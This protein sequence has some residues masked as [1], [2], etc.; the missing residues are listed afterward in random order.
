MKKIFLSISLLCAV[1]FTYA[2]TQLLTSWSGQNTSTYNYPQAGTSTS[3]VSSSSQNYNGLNTVSDNRNVWGNPNASSVLDPAT[4][5]YLE[6]SITT[7]DSIDF[8]RFVLGGAANMNTSTKMQLRWDVDSFGS[9]LGEFTP[10]GSN[11]NLTSVDINAQSN[12]PAGTVVFRIYYYNGIGN[13]FHVGYFG[14]ASVD[15]TPASYGV[16]GS[17]SFGIWG[18]VPV[19]PCTPTSATDVV[20]ACNSYT[21]I[22]GITYTAS[23]N[24]ATDTL[25]NAA[26]C[27]SVVS[28]DL[29][30]NTA[31]SSADTLTACDSYSWNGNMYTVSGSYVDTL[32]GVNTCDSI[33]TLELTITHSSSSIDS[34]TACDSYA[35]I[36]GYT[37]YYSNY[38]DTHI[39]TNAA[40]CDSIVT[41]ALTILESTHS[42]TSLFTYDSSYT[43]NGNVYD[44]SNTYTHNSTNAAGCDS[45]TF[46]DLTFLENP[47]DSFP[48]SFCINDSASYSI[49]TIASENIVGTGVSN[50]NF[51]PNTAGAGSHTL[52]SEYVSNLSYD[53]DSNGTF[54]YIN[55]DAVADSVFLEDDD[56][57]H[58][59]G[60]M[61][62]LD[63]PFNY[64]GVEVDS[65]SI[66]SNGWI[67]FDSNSYDDYA[68]GLPVYDEDYDNSI[69]LIDVDLNPE[70][71][72]GFSNGLI[73][74][75][76]VGL[77]PNR[78]LVVEFDSVPFYE[79]NSVFYSAQLHL[80]EGSNLIEIHTLEA[81]NLLNGDY[82]SQ[83]V[84]SPDENIAVVVPGRDDQLWSVNNDYMAFIPTAGD[85]ATIAHTVTV[86]STSTGTDAVTACNSYTWID[87]IT[88]TASNNTASMTFTNTLGCDSVVTLNLIIN[89][90][91]DLSTTFDGYVLTSNN[92]AATSYAWLD[93]YDNYSFIN[94]ETAQT[95]TVTADGYYAVEITENGCVDTS[96]C[97]EIV[98]LSSIE[99]IKSSF[100][101]GFS[102]YPN[103]TNGKVHLS[104][105]QAQEEL[106][107]SLYALN[108]QLIQEERFNG[109]SQL[110]F[111][112]EAPA[113]MYLLNISNQE[114]EKA[115][116]RLVKY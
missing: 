85:T 54:G 42:N 81:N 13:V 106:T 65:F 111:E 1:M 40:G 94:G 22:D 67:T 97:V 77:S 108:G 75:A 8:D 114:G 43:W 48:T 76:T 95:F 82:A 60:N 90:V 15:G 55:I 33:A 98:D 100:S 105:T 86:L 69:F 16:S 92:T 83:G 88:Y 109:L 17:V 70:A 6:F 18:A 84:Q 46:L 29:T 63:F 101:D 41:L 20:T 19:T 25:T 4:A 31:V 52:T 79:D 72:N 32:I 99:A 115:I 93:C 34:I 66:C 61:Y 24:S 5:P 26:G 27:D 116:I 47:F 2:Q 44:S 59:Y 7:T 102:L 30:I 58:Y 14:Y 56:M 103:P 21:W 71:G 64:W 37:Y 104:F 112:V 49:T 12:V 39:L 74:H 51:S 91:S 110:G 78:I 96:D 10:N 107:I 113:G 62:A 50:N 38:S 57:T 3:L 28:L 36:N 73:K 23:N 68:I 53:I 87:G 89:S 45:T 35:W 11:Y 9:S 80:H